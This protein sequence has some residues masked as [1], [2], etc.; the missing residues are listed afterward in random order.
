MNEDNVYPL[1]QIYFYLTEGCNLRC[2][3]CWIS[4]R[5][6]TAGRSYS[7]L[8][9]DLFSSIIG[10]AIPMGLTGVKLT[11]GEPLL[12]PLIGEMLDFI[13]TKD[14]GL[15]METNGVLL[16][17]ELAA[18]IASCNA[19][20]IA[21]S[22]DGADAESHEWIRGVKG[23]FEPALKAI[24]RLAREGLQPQ[25]IMTIMQRNRDQIEDVVHLAE[26]LGAGSIKFNIVQPT[27]RG[28]EMHSTGES[29]TLEEY[30][31]IGQWVEDELS[32][33][34]GLPLFYSHPPA[35][36]P[37]HRLFGEKG[38]G[39][40]TCGIQGIIGVLSNG[41]YAL[42]GIGETV[43]EL[44]FGHAATDRLAD[45]W[46][47][48]PVLREIREGLPVRFK[49][50]CRECVMLSRCLGNCLAQNYYSSKDFWTPYWYCEQALEKGLFPKTRIREGQDKA[51]L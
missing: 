13:R 50:I 25:I 29:L 48:S 45:V 28:K 44:V 34:A 27:A 11:G 20:F 6:Q 18:K 24:G 36:Q 49:G 39:C 8:D 30:I 1:N 37:L 2:R 23:C 38:T 5:H 9:I 22:L 7:S 33:K 43:H 14:L 42:C 3:H 32:K 21:I 19:P 10:Q 35:F 40:A 41:G 26:S 17:G 31:R 51:A 16:T 46:R 15:D 12:H 4:P 47:D